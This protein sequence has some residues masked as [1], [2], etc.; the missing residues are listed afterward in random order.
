MRLLNLFSKFPVIPSLVTTSSHP[1]HHLLPTKNLSQ[2]KKRHHHSN[3]KVNPRCLSFDIIIVE[4]EEPPM[5]QTFCQQNNQWRKLQL[6]GLMTCFCFLTRPDSTVLEPLTPGTA[7]LSEHLPSKDT[8]SST[9][10]TSLGAKNHLPP[11][12]Q[13]FIKY[14]WPTILRSGYFNQCKVKL[15]HTVI[16]L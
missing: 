8:E 7:S 11:G 14:N 15:L 5:L 13:H 2:I 16:L 3:P 4:V 12:R 6:L 9:K 10:E 1:V